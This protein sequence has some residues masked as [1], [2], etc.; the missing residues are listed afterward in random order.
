MSDHRNEARAEAKPNRGFWRLMRVVA[1]GFFG[2]R[3]AS[4]HQSDL[5]RISPL[6]IVLAG[7]IGFVVLIAVLVAAAHWMAHTI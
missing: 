1:W 2:V 5:A 7:L 6:H 4:S 3:K